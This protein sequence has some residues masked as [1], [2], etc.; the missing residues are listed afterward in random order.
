MKK[1][2]LENI[3]SY[4]E[5]SK[6]GHHQTKKDLNI[7]LGW[8]YYAQIRISKPSKVVCIGS[9]RGFV[10]IILAQALKDNKK[11]KLIFI[12]PSMVDDFW[13]DKKKTKLWFEK[14]NLTN[15]EHHCVTTQT[16]IETKAYKKLN[17]V[18]LIFIDGY[19]TAKQAEF[20]FNAFK[21]K[22]TDNA[23]IFFHDSVR[24]F[25]TSIY[26]KDKAY[27][28]DVYKFINKIKKWKKFQVIDFHEGSGVTL[29]KKVL[30]K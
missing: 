4:P 12:D 24:K 29:V 11:G 8:L 10:P 21:S 9:W 18:G 16:F 17:N 23:S 30:E 26:G 14:F 1:N 5:L 2:W 3:F 25:I 13:R 28:H 19:H 20:D 22:L 6:M 7:G 27:T 15:I